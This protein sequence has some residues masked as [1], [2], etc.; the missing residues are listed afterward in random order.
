MMTQDDAMEKLREYSSYWD[1]EAFK[2]SITLFPD[3]VDVY[4]DQLFYDET[5]VPDNDNLKA[6]ATWKP[7]KK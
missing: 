2:R 7:S 3:T 1:D 4:K 6:W 5:E